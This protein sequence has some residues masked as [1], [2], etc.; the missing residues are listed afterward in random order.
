MVAAAQDVRE[1]LAARGL[2]AFCRTTGGK[3]LHVVVPL[4][5]RADWDRG[6]QPGA[7]P[8]P[9]RWQAEQ[10][11]RYVAE[12]PKAKRRGRILIDWLRNGL[13]ATAIASFSPRARPGA[14]VATP[15]AWSEVTA[16]L[17]P[18]RFTLRTL[19]ERL[20]RQRRDPWAGFAAAARPLPDSGGRL[21]AERAVWRGHLRLALV[22]C[23]VALYTAHHERGNLHFHLINPETGNRVRMPT[24]D[25]ET[26]TELSRRDL[27]AGLRVPKDQLP[28]PDDAD[29]DR[30]ADRQF[31]RC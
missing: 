14:G 6:P 29:F 11:E 18:A 28:D 20:G 7:A 1:R 23:P 15:L 9:R 19:P 25:A 12:V 8:S 31:D 30:R 21:M 5:P 26:G 24:V 13:G 4:V 2:G 17:D 3:G 27:V 22:S 16:K 10:P